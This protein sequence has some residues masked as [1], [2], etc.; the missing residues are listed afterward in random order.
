MPWWITS[1][2]FP[3]MK[4]VKRVVRLPPLGLPS[5]L[6][7]LTPKEGGRSRESGEGAEGKIGGLLLPSIRRPPQQVCQRAGNTTTR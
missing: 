1:S 6:T 7:P 5:N 3:C 4:G 2:F